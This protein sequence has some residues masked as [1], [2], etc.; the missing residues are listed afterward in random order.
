MKQFLKVVAEGYKDRYSD[1]SFLTFVMP[2]KRSGT[3]LLKYFKELSSKTII[4]PRIITISDLVEASTLKVTDSRLDLLFR[5]YNCYVG[6]KSDT[7]LSFEKFNAWGE[8]ILSDYNEIDMHMINAEE[9]FRNVKDLNDIKSDFLTEEQKKIMVEY[10]GYSPEILDEE[11]HR[12][13]KDPLRISSKKDRKEGVIGERFKSLWQLLWPLYE[14]FKKSLTQNGLT[15]EGG[16]YRE[17]VEKMEKGYE[18]FPGE[19]LIFVGFNALSGSERRMFAALRDMT[20]SINNREEMKA[21]FVWDVISTQFE[22]NDDPAIRFVR[23]NKKDFPSPGWLEL[24][25]TLSVPSEKPLI[26]VMAVPSNIMQVKLASRQLDAWKDD[27]ERRKKEIEDVRVAVI[28]PDETLLLPLLHSLPEKYRKP[29]LTMGFPLKQTPVI[30]FASLLRKLHARS[31]MSKGAARF[32]MEDIR[33]LLSHPYSTVIF[34]RKAISDLIGHCEKKRYIMVPATILEEYLGKNARLVFKYFGETVGAHEIIQYISAILIKVRGNMLASED[35]F[36]TSSVECTYISAYTDALIRLDNAISDYSIS[37]SPSGVFSLADRLIAG[38]KIA[39]E[40]E[41]LSGLQIMGVLETRCLDFDRIVM[42]SLN[43]KVMPR[44]GRNSTFIPNFLRSAYGMP[45]A[46]YQEEI[47]AYYFFRVLNRCERGLLTFDSRSTENRTPGPS[48][49][50]LQ[51]KYLPG[52]FDYRELEAVFHKGGSSQSTISIGKDDMIAAMLEK[53]FATKHPEKKFSASSL[54]DYFKCHLKFLFKDVMGMYIDREPTETI[55][56]IDMG[57]IIHQA[58]E[59]L[60]IIDRGRPS[61]VMLKDP[62]VMTEESLDA[63]LNRRL[64]NGAPY[65]EEVVKKEILKVHFHM[66]GISIYNGKLTGSAAII[67]DNIVEYVKGII[68]ADK[69][70][71]PFRLWGSEIRETLPY[72]IPGKDDVN[73]VMVIDR[74]DQEGISDDGAFR[75]IDYKTGSVHLTADTFDDIFNGSYDAGNIFQLFLY[76]E[77]L[78]K[79]VEKWKNMEEKKRPAMP[80]GFYKEELETR[81]KLMIYGVLRFLNPKQSGFVEVEIGKGRKDEKT[82]ATMA[83]L[84]VFELRNGVSF[85]GRLNDILLEILDTSV[86]FTTEIS[87]QRCAFCEYRLRCEM[88]ANRPKEENEE[89]ERFGNQENLL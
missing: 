82:I 52:S 25:L 54:G 77:L 72:T 1:L 30:S 17:A 65:I 28:L 32:Y 78:L 64:A 81:L 10:F 48:R 19:K 66:N 21:D 62:V 29:N 50:I 43:E 71:A 70:R 16:A 13:W 47:F 41:P 69:S 42:L 15:T 86:P 53:Y 11:N 51:M 75:I 39:F 89:C 14:S 33:D 5:L 44:V 63:I 85:L 58:M 40:G 35:T 34:P 45:P 36:M 18:P 56:A 73:M 60:Y 26:E 7:E 27:D 9:I 6:L 22:E 68:K 88:L 37:I 55:D 80:P 61:G 3:F 2:N 49:Y 74:L 59:R 23:E 79:L 4:A 38:E 84:R 83:D 8:S 12:L 57:S 20:V 46:N 24:P 67:F 87:E 76:G 31:S